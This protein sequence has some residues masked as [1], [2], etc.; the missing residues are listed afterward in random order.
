MRKYTIALL[1]LALLAVTLTVVIAVTPAQ[2]KDAPDKKPVRAFSGKVVSV[3][4]AQNQI[5]IKDGNDAETTLLIND[6]TTIMKNEKAITFAEI[7]VNDII[8]G[9]CEDAENGCIA[10]TI[11]VEAAKPDGLKDEILLS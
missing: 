7:T 2:Q 5:V 3:D 4:A 8:S 9:E 6:R 1:T 11:K 10:I